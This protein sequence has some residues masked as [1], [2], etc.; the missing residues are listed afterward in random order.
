MIFVDMVASELGF[1]LHYDSSG[2]YFILVDHKKR[3]VNLFDDTEI[4]RSMAVNWMIKVREREK[5][6]ERK[7]GKE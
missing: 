6:R 1:D 2:E 7:R 3:I 5:R 4:N